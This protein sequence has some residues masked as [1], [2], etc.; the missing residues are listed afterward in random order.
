[1]LFGL[2]HLDATASGRFSF[3]RVPF[4]C[5]VGIAF[6]ALRL[7]SGRLL[8]SM[9]AHFTLN[10]ITFAVAPLSELPVDGNLPDPRPLLGLAMF[11]AGTLAATF[12]IR[13]TAR[14]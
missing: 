3:Y 8:S 9:I 6:A 1:L 12:L 7:S 5:A 11:A 10:T 14:D 13:R 4:A 2:I